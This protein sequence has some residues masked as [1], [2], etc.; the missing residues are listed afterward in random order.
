MNGDTK[1]VRVTQCENIPLREGRSV[2]ID[3]R[4][5]AIFNLGGRFFAI[6]NTCPHKGGPLS[7]GIVSGNAVVCP[8][9]A[10][11]VDLETGRVVNQA[12]DVP[13]VATYPTRVH[14]GVVQIELPAERSA[15][16]EKFTACAAGSERNAKPVSSG[17]FCSGLLTP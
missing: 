10:W 8:L 7:E 12:G 13:C 3:T 6:D 11:K 15:E 14:D 17:E 4:E 16:P 9:H 2:R 1:W 5:I